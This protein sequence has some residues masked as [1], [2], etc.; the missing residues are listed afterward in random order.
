MM[1]EKC[2]HPEQT[3]GI[4]LGL[5]ALNILKY[6]EKVADASADVQPFVAPTDNF[7]THLDLT[8]ETAYEA[9]A[10]NS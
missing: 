9:L 1:I 10:S 2:L 6:A 4:D 3:I 5:K 8:G 7:E